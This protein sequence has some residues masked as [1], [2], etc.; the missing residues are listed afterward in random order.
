MS[1]AFV[2]G[3]QLDYVHCMKSNFLLIV[4]FLLATSHGLA[5]QTPAG[6]STNVPS[7]T[8]TPPGVAEPVAPYDE[9]LLRLSE[10]LGAVHYLRSLCG[11][12]ESTKW[13]DVMS[14]ILD[15]ETPGP[16]RKSRLIAHFNRGYR[17]FSNSYSD[18]TPSAIVA[19]ER[20]MKEGAD[21]SARIAN[22]YGR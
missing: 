3:R 20:Y 10:V 5:Q 12:D 21:L 16:Q 6:T 2:P 19:S 11:A 14:A 8:S 1:L 18:C 22:R 4:M 13:R 17:T 7:P 15:A 9:Q